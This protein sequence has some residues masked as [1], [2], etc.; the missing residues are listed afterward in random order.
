[1][2]IELNQHHSVF[3]TY[4]GGPGLTEWWPGGAAIVVCGHT[5]CG[6]C[7]LWHCPSCRLPVKL[8]AEI[9]QLLTFRSGHKK[10]ILMM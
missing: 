1:M 7:L 9:G 4:D 10:H 8:H 5:W 2:K 6:L 3:S